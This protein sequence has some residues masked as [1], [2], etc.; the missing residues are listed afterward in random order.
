MMICM[1]R[2]VMT[3][4][5]L[6]QRMA[7]R[8]PINSD[9]KVAWPD[10][11][12]QGP[13][14]GC[15]EYTPDSFSDGGR[16]FDG[17]ASFDAILS[18]ADCCLAEG[19]TILD[20]GGE[21]TRPGAAPVSV[22]E[23]LDR[24][25]PVVEALSSR[26]DTVISVDTSTP[27]VQI[28]SAAHGARMINDVRAL[29]REGAMAAA[30]QTGLPVCLMHM[31]GTPQTMQNQPTYDDAVDDVYQWLMTRV[32]V[33]RDA[34][35]DR[36][37]LLLD[38]GFGFGKTFEHNVALFRSLDRFVQSGYPVLVGV[39]RKTMIGDMTG[40]Q[41]NN[42]SREVRWQRLQHRMVLQFCVHDVAE[43]RDAMAVMQTLTQEYSKYESKYFGTDGVRGRVGEGCITAEFVLKLGWAFGQTVRQG[44]PAVPRS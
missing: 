9:S 39:S 33:C 26:F 28:E 43:T 19:A 21:S 44:I 14:H 25:V 20:V 31:Q 42:V 1:K 41:S 16:L 15:S 30:L 22:S 4:L 7:Q 10:L 24:V 12:F 2:R 3:L 6:L 32:D 23:E 36:N 40:C 11:G 18:H 37:Q 8:Q 5:I 34:G 13:G 38:P 17:Q 29:L 35:F 27:N